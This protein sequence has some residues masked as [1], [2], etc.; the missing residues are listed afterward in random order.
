MTI[1]EFAKKYEISYHLAWEASY[2]VKPV[3]TITRDK[4]FPEDEL[5]HSVMRILSSKIQ[6][7]YN[8]TNDLQQT[9][10]RLK[11]RRYSQ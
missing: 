6:D 4:D 2:D 8:R 10:S 1:R 3:S 5:Y 11:W 9:K 7:C